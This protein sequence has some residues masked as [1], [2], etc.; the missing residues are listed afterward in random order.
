MAVTSRFSDFSANIKALF[1][2][3]SFAATSTVPADTFN[4]AFVNSQYLY[5]PPYGYP[6][7]V[8]IPTLRLLAKSPFVFMVTQTII[9]EV[10]SVEWDIVPKERDEPDNETA[11]ESDEAAE[12]AS[13]GSQPKTAK[14][15]TRPRMAKTPQPVHRPPHADTTQL[16]RIK[17]VKDWFYNPNGNEESFETLL[18]AVLRDLLEVDA[19]V[20]VKSFDRSGKFVQLFARDG[21]TFLKN[22]DIHGYLGN[23][24]EYVSVPEFQS[25][26]AQSRY[27]DTI[28]KQEAAYFQ[29][30][31][32]AAMPIP[33]GTRELIYMMRNPRSDSIYGRSPLEILYSTL[34]TLIYGQNYN[35]DFYTN[36]NMPEG[37]IS[38][39]NADAQTIKAFRER[40]EPQFRQT[41]DFGVKVKSFFKIPITNTPVE[42]VPFQ[43]KPVD[44][45]ILEQQKWFSKLVW[46]CFGVTA[47][48][49]GFTEDSNRATEIV[50]GKVFRRKTV[51]PLLSLLAY[52]I[53][54]QLMPEFGY[55]D[56]EFRF[57]DYDIAEDLERHKL[58][59]IQLRNN[60]RTINE[61]RED[62]GL[63]PKEGGDDLKAPNPF[64]AMLPGLPGASDPS[65]PPE[66][67]IPKKAESMPTDE[68]A[69]PTEAKAL[70]PNS[71]EAT[72]DLTAFLQDV[73][74]VLVKE[75]DALYTKDQLK[76]IKGF[77][78]L[79]QRLLANLNKIIVPQSLKVTVD[80]M[81]KAAYVKGLEGS[82][83]EFAQNF[84]PNE[85]AV[86]FLQTYN[87]DLVKAMNE[88]LA[89]KLRA[90]LQRGFLNN[91][92]RAQLVEDVK[93]LF[94]SS[95]SRAETIVRT[96]TNRAQNM[97]R[98][99]GA[100][101]SHLVKE[102][103]LL[104]PHPE[105]ELC[106]RMLAKYGG[107]TIPLEAQFVDE[108]T[109]KSFLSPPFHPNCK[110]RIVTPRVRQED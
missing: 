35:L 8:D 41:N 60:I 59:E 109:G 21:G 89:N 15:A 98:L 69:P 50:Q 40:F 20:F 47:S 72:D 88:D 66:T 3:V 46:A 51:R 92:P 56:L 101:Q 34:Q 2:P 110:T 57:K 73:Q 37:I 16:A 83:E 84:F 93:S 52:H 38:L 97:G 63:D 58:Y 19:G 68:A 43:L 49:L 79:W 107:E 76:Q 45:Q 90:T 96:E 1:R 67:P 53:N 86:S 103:S 23:R 31:F 33:F 91:A 39:L 32:V 71:E 30:G 14:T 102:K 9:D 108:P 104:N 81:T 7:S 99:D 74:A 24:A 82:E 106:Q 22:P 17:E 36:N 44:M 28:L 6:R 5:K 65:K 105:S 13:L 42:F 18:R 75:I 70:P 95:E 10:A 12:V 78:D 100:K 85:K 4:K 61:I 55:D 26:T 29:Y 62:L 80:Q 94:K 87:F 54:S 25:E 64:S 11:D 27:Y 77:S 48:E